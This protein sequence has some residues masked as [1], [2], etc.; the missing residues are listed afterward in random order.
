MVAR[1]ARLWHEDD[2]DL[3]DALSAP[4][5]YEPKPLEGLQAGGLYMLVGPR[6]VGKSV[7]FKRA[8]K[9][10]LDSGIDRRRIFHA[11]CNGWRA[12]DLVT[13]LDVGNGLAPPADG[14]RYFFLDE[15]T[16][17][18]DDWVAQIT[19]LRDNS[20]LR[21]DCVVL[22]GS[23]AT[24]LDEA[25]KAL[26]DRRGTADPSH[27]TLL[28]MGFRA[29]C[30][31]TRVDVP[32]VPTIHPRDML[33]REAA[34]AIGELRPFLNDH[35]IAWER[36]LTVGGFPRAVGDWIG[37]REISRWF[38]NGMWDVIHG[39]ALRSSGWSPAQTQA[40]LEAISRSL[41]SPFNAAHAARDLGSI[42]H[43]ALDARLRA[44]VEN[45]IV[46]PCAQNEGNRPKL[47]SRNKL[48]FVDPLH[49]R[50][51]SQRKSSVMPPDFTQLTE[52]QIGGVL[53]RSLEAEEPG[54]LA[55]YDVLLYQRTPARKEIDFTGAFLGRLPYEGKYTEGRWLRGAAT[56]AAA[57]GRGVFATRNLTERKDDLLAVPAPFIALMLDV[58]PFGAATGA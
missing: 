23:S 50:L 29:F 52:Q 49:A 40:L 44:L 42:H 5:S 11:A 13:L 55:D 32:E 38:L 14:A 10:L 12:R 25:R 18:S 48:Y 4:F 27:R 9:A 53:L 47:R 15:I 41:A 22:S 34:Q 20:A 1:G 56:A 30:E 33:G 16:S 58:T 51:A 26:A 17:I 28:P 19:W 36:Y 45:Y 6:R 37:E 2:R 3:R 57:Y 7:E 31:A 35:V 8:V 43:D 21:D 46:W 39:D 54:S 24:R